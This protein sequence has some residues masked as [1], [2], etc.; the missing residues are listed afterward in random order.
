MHWRRPG[1]APA[2]RDGRPRPRPLPSSGHPSW[3]EALARVGY[4]ARGALYL[5]VGATGLLVAVGLAEQAR[6]SADALRLL[7][8]LPMGWVL[9]AA[10]AVGCIGYSTLSLVAALRAPE[11]PAAEHA[12]PRRLATRVG[13]AASGVV[14]AGLAALAVRLLGDPV[15]DAGIAGVAW[16]AR[17]LALPGGRAM[18]AGGGVIVLGVA[19][20]LAGR[21]V[22]GPVAERIERRGMRPELAR[23]IVRLARVGTA[24]RAALFAVIGG[25]L[26]R[27]AWRR[28]ATGVGGL[29]D[30]LDVLDDTAIGPVLVALASAGCVAY[31]LYQLAKA[32]FRRLT[33]GAVAAPRGALVTRPAG[34]PRGA[35]LSRSRPP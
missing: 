5:I 28:D 25:L 13:D 22:V 23:A 8:R 33:L 2:P 10:I 16:G 1:D 4:V 24:A 14:Y 26:V 21:A 7:A 3:L 6:G 31:G 18:L 29:G 32:R 30:A 27:A 17:V 15:N 34:D 12:A 20:Y 19:A 35:P 9:L 11:E